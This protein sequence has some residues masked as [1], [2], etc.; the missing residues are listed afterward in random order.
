MCESEQSEPPG[1]RV[2]VVILAAGQGTRMRSPLP[3][4]LHPVAGQPM[5]Q[6]V[7]ALPEELG[8]VIRAVVVAPGQDGVRAVI[9]NAV[10]VEQVP[11]LGT[12][13]AVLQARQAL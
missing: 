6:R 5:L 10:T 1:P 13:H 8:S 4:V 12:G 2:G 7:L 11:Q 3:K 9:T